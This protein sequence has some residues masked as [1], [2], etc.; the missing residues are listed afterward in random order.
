MVRRNQI[1][2][3]QKAG[4][5]CVIYGFCV[6]DVATLLLIIY[7]NSKGGGG[8]ETGGGTRGKGGSTGA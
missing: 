5:Q 7:R 4:M 1:M 6:F 3:S 8:T 2:S